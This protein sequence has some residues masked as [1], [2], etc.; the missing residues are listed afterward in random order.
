MCRNDEP[1]EPQGVPDAQTFADVADLLA[2]VKPGMEL[3]T[4]DFTGWAEVSEVGP[5]G[6]R[7]I[8]RSDG[9]AVEVPT[10]A[11]L[12]IRGGHCVRVDRVKA[13]IDAQGWEIASPTPGHGRPLSAHG[14]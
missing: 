12:D 1:R 8:R 6:V 9:M 5:G 2:A 11:L 7:G 4:S 3:C 10:G 13:T 14:E